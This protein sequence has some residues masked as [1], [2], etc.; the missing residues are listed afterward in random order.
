[1]PGSMTRV[2]PND[3]NRLSL[4]G[5]MRLVSPNLAWAPNGKDLGQPLRR[6]V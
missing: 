6:V 1:M 4:G 5:W 2:N 3:F